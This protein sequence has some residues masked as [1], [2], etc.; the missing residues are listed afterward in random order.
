MKMEEALIIIS[1]LTISIFSGQTKI[2]A[3]KIVQSETGGFSMV[4]S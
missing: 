3:A 1:D 2:N 4:R